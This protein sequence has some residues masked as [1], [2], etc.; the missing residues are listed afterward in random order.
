MKSSSPPL[1]GVTAETREFQV[2]GSQRSRLVNPSGVKQLSSVVKTVR[3]R[4]SRLQARRDERLFDE[5]GEME[6][7]PSAFKVE[8]GSFI[9]VNKT[10][11]V[12]SLS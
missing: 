6:A 5:A 9:D 3:V 7:A 4:H 11:S 8:A 2:Q 10:G 12:T 1:L